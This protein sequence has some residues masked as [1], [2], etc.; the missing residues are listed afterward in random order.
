M[1]QQKT[2]GRNVKQAKFL[3]NNHPCPRCRSVLPEKILPQRLA[4]LVGVVSIFSSHQSSSQNPKLSSVAKPHDVT[5][6]ATPP[7]LQSNGLTAAQ[8]K[9]RTATRNPRS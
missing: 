9:L 3:S 6:H 5:L 4:A 2:Y 1:L 8:A 7:S